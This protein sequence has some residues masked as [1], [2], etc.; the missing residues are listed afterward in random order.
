MKKLLTILV[1][2][3]SACFAFAENTF[4]GSGTSFGDATVNATEGITFDITAGDAELAG[5]E[6]AGI[7]FWYS[8][9][10]GT[11]ADYGIITNY[12]SNTASTPIASR[13]GMWANV[14]NKNYLKLDTSDTLFRSI[15]GLNN[16]YTAPNTVNI[17]E[18][19]YFDSLVQ[20]T[21]T[22]D[23]VTPSDGD[24]L[25]V[26]LKAVEAAEA[27]MDGETEVKP[28]VSAST[29]LMITA[30]VPG[31][32]TS[33]NP[34]SYEV[35]NIS[36]KP[37]DWARLTIKSFLKEGKPYFSV[38][39]NGVAVDTA[40]RNEFLSLVD[41]ETE[42][43]TTISAVGFKGTGAVDDLAFTTSDPLVQTFPLSIVVPEG[44]EVITCFV[45]EDNEIEA[46]DGVYLIDVTA[47]ADVKAWVSVPDGY[48]V[49]NVGATYDETGKY[50]VVPV[51]IT[52]ATANAP[53]SFTV[54]VEAKEV[55][56]A[57]PF[58]V[59]IAAGTTKEYDTIKEALDAALASDGATI[60][61]AEK[62]GNVTVPA[63][64]I[65]NSITIDL[66]GNTLVLEDPGVGANETIKTLGI[67]IGGAVEQDYAK[68]IN[69][70]I[71]NGKI[72]VD[73]T[74]ATNPIMMMIQNYANLAL[75][76][77]ELDGTNLVKPS[78]MDIY[79]LS[80]NS[81]NVLLDGKTKI[82]APSGGYAF[83]A[84]YSSD[85][86]NYKAP[87]VTLDLDDEGSINGNIEIDG[88]K[89]VY[90]AGTINGEIKF[91][92]G[93]ISVAE[94][95]QN[96]IKVPTG[97][98][99]V[100]DNG[101]WI[102]G[103]KTDPV[104][105]EVAPEVDEE[106]NEITTTEEYSDDAKTCLT[107]YFPKGTGTDEAPIALQVVINGETLLGDEAVKAIND[108]AAKFTG[109]PFDETGKINLVFK[110]DDVMKALAGTADG[111]TLTVGTAE[112]KSTYEVAPKFIDLATGA[113]IQDPGAG[114]TAK[115]FKLVVREKSVQ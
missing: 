5:T 40:V 82:V 92:S 64:Q 20:F 104:L 76:D 56:A 86:I 4:T 39:V 48:K 99:L 42:G 8:L 2:A 14:A 74:G 102:L 113:E 38:F 55:P 46:T 28:P 77:L 115:F 83:D 91:L 63:F 105:P 60:T 73:N 69:V 43:Y 112:L 27:V 89:F 103:D 36:V 31:E 66:G 15:N 34:V 3:A 114:A 67:R 13:P 100:V 47:T 111:Y 106:G 108:V 78:N 41:S 70:T 17:G 26:W 71:M 50:W 109:N 32:G 88:G 62:T 75:I 25:I 57:K 16:E 33:I 87:M 23:D 1:S 110:V 11:D 72:A 93:A 95:I 21:A 80:N 49:T 24:K 97:K 45:G 98:E 7:R 9:A 68:L 29:N 79:V 22:E 37:N 107:T 54:T 84:Y 81:G 101:V 12:E 52:G 35:T 59:T 58:S 18:G 90:T 61:I 53:V 44:S 19:I 30:G 94:A 10:S 85:W 51:S 96:Q 6:N 65:N